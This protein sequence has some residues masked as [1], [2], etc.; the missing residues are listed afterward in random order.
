[1][2]CWDGPVYGFTPVGHNT[3]DMAVETSI[4]DFA[5]WYWQSELERSTGREMVF[6]P[7]TQGGNKPA[8]TRDGQLKVIFPHPG[9]GYVISCTTTDF[10]NGPQTGCCMASLGK[11]H[12][13]S[14][15]GG[16]DTYEVRSCYA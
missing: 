9:G 4:D 14:S 2:T 16:V 6:V 7:A 3:C 8:C 10:R 15:K 13:T 12:A 5:G 11:F 1:M